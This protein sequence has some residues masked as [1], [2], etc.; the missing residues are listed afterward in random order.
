MEIYN[1]SVND[2]IEP[3]NKNLDIRESISNGIY[4]NKLSEKTVENFDN[5]MDFMSKGDE[6]R[7]IEP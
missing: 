4:I 7:N 3:A 2:L 5:V 6:F 1:E